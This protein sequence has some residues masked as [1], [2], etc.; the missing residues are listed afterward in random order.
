MSP[1]AWGRAS[2]ILSLALAGAFVISQAFGGPVGYVIVS[3]RSMEPML[4]T[5]D[6]ALV[7]RRGSY[8]LGDVVAFRVPQGEPGAGSVVIH[9]VVGGTAQ[10]GYVTQGDNRDGRDP[11]RPV[12]ADVVG[13]MALHVPKLGRIP[14]FLASPIGVALG[15]ALVLFL[16]VARTGSPNEKSGAA[17]GVPP[18]GV[19]ATQQAPDAAPYRPAATARVAA[20][21]HRLRPTV[22][23]AGAVAGATAALLVLR[24]AR[25]R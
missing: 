23:T 8:R 13:E 7:V 11:W 25:R 4:H 21:P 22:I 6:L 9:R 2:A 12:T 3:G 1:R 20:P 17:P 10:D 15:A 5:G 24:A 14:A 19:D 16:L 18:V